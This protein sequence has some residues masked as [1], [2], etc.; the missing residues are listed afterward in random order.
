MNAKNMKLGM[1]S[2]ENSTVSSFVDNATTRTIKSG[3]K[4]FVITKLDAFGQMEMIINLTAIFGNSDIFSS[5]GEGGAVIGGL[6]KSISA[7]TPKARED[8]YNITL[9]NV[10]RKDQTGVFPI[11]NNGGI[12]Y[13]D[14]DW[15]D[16]VGLMVANVRFNLGNFSELLKK[17]GKYSGISAL[18]NLNLSMDLVTK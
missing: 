16:L 18:V 5:N 15:A 4:E 2:K 9:G 14:L 8:I 17:I 10:Y 13:D 3:D 1:G 11:Y 6:I 12:N 7:L